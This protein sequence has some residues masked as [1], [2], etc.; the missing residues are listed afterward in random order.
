MKNTNINVTSYFDGM[1]CV[2]LALQKQNIGVD[3]YFA[4][5]IDKYAK[6]VTQANF[7]EGQR[8]CLEGFSLDCCVLCFPIAF[9]SWVSVFV[10][11]VCCVVFVLLPI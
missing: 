7:P 11:R 3:N 2:Q 10:S 5:E 8:L 1:S 6:K 4:Y 9:A